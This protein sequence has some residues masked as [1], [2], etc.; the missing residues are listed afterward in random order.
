MTEFAFPRPEYCT[1][2]GRGGMTLRDYFAAQ[3]LIGFGSSGT[4][5]SAD[6]VAEKC[7]DLADA[8]LKARQ[9]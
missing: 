2:S 3:A 6:A 8:M 7:Y 1:T 5:M 4:L 9:K